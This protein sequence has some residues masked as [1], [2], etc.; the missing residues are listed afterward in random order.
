MGVL[1][2]SRMSVKVLLG[3]AVVVA[4]VRGYT[5]THCKDSK[6]AIV[7]LF[8]WS[9]DAVADECTKVLGPKGFCGV[10]VSP[11]N[12]HIQGGQ[13]WT[14][15]QPVSYKLESRSGNRGQFID[16][17]NRCKSAGVNIYVD[18]VINHMTGHGGS[19]QGTGGS[20]YDG[21]YENFP[22]VPFGIQDFHQPYC[23]VS[24]Y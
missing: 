17:V 5:E 12:E 2:R 14:R 24:N 10:Q 18:A 11:P 3:L 4:R 21:P 8:E 1:I 20:G 16:M 23:D 22:G 7:H 15:Y 13:W 19:G 9:W 6:Q